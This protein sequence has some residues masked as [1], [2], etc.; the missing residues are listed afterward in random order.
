[1]RELLSVVLDLDAE[2]LS[3]LDFSK[4]LGAVIKFLTCFQLQA[5][6]NEIRVYV[7]LPNNSY[8]LYPLESPAG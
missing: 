2:K 5:A 7:A 4:F 1:M 8:L 3:H 6:T